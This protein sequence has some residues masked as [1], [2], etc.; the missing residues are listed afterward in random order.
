MLCLIVTSILLYV[1]VDTLLF[2][3]NQDNRFT[4]IQYIVL[5]SVALFLLVRSSRLKVGF[6]KTIIG[7]VIALLGLSFVTGILNADL[8]I[9]YIYE[10]VLLVIALL[11]VSLFGFEEFSRAFIVALSF[12]AAFSLVLM[13]VNYVAPS[14]TNMLPYITNIAHQGFAFGGFGFIKVL[15]GEASR[16]IGIFREPAVFGIFVDL[17]LILLLFS[18]KHGISRRIP[19]SMLLIVT[20]FTVHSSGATVCAIAILMVYAINSTT[21]KMPYHKWLLLLLA[22]AGAFAYLYIADPLDTY[23]L[24]KF[25]NR[26]YSSWVDRSF[27]FLGNISIFLS[28]PLFGSGWDNGISEFLALSSQYSA[29]STGANTNTFLRV[30]S[31]HGIICFV[32]WLMGM[33]GFCKQLSAK[34]LVRVALLVVVFLLLANAN[35][36]FNVYV[37]IMV[38]YGWRLQFAKAKEEEATGATQPQKAARQDQAYLH[39]NAERVQI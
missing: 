28:H 15:G 34:T 30:L 36:T 8:G 25:G 27:S 31:V 35:L 16:N 24:S 14:A 26:E 11:Y 17:A 18:D 22:I 4:L 33:Y 10:A 3:T 7:I 19:V 32:L 37:L 9:K 21:K 5:A 13:A 2:G 6:N 1:S 20:L 29:Y 38:G 12:L 23:E 39:P